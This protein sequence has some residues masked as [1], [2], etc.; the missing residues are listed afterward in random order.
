MSLYIV[1]EIINTRHG[2]VMLN[3]ELN[4]E[5]MRFIARPIFFY[6]DKKKNFEDYN[7]PIYGELQLGAT[8]CSNEFVSMQELHAGFLEGGKY[9]M[10][11]LNYNMLVVSTSSKEMYALYQQMVKELRK[12]FN[13]IDILETE[14]AHALLNTWP[15]E[16]VEA[17]NVTSNGVFKDVFFAIKKD[18][19][20]TYK[21]EW[22]NKS[23]EIMKR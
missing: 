16:V 17:L 22:W 5:V 11:E 10:S 6:K 13:N 14:E 7:V 4:R 8:V 12:E 18:S 9:L 15:K 3:D 21:G 20:E 2:V 1:K 23:Q 19:L